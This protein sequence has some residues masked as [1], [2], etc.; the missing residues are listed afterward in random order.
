MNQG[1]KGFAV[2]PNLAYACRQSL[3]LCLLLMTFSV[4][5]AKPDEGCFKGIRILYLPAASEKFLGSLFDDLQAS[6]HKL[7]DCSVSSQASLN[8]KDFIEWLMS[9]PFELV[10]AP[11]HSV[12]PIADRLEYRP[13]VAT[14][15]LFTTRL[16]SHRR[17]SED[18]LKQALIGQTVYTPDVMSGVFLA[19]EQWLSE[20]DIRYRVRLVPGYTHD[21]LIQQVAAKQIDF[22]V[23][24]DVFVTDSMR[25]SIQTS[26]Y[27]SLPLGPLYLLYSSK[28]DPDLVN[29]LRVALLDYDFVPL[30]EFLKTEKLFVPVSTYPSSFFSD[31]KKRFMQLMAPGFLSKK[32]E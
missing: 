29:Y 24:A 19:L 28:L 6:L 4:C 21:Y 10:L 16:I 14:E 1:A 12:Q 7:T 17:L 2:A 22:A 31:K 8:Y 9:E 5:L 26:A 11:A 18:E 3:P 32:P 25:P 23:V 27:L 13:L 30:K 20:Q 15:K